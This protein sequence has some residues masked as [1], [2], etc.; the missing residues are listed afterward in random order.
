[1]APS[2][3]SGL[4]GPVTAG[5]HY[6]AIVESSDDA[7]LSKDPDGLITSWN[8]AAERMY[9]Y[10][11]EEAVGSHISILIPKH[12]S[13]EE[14][15]ILDRIL[16][17]E[18]VDH[19][20]TERVRKDGRQINVSLSVSPVRGADGKVE[21][22]SVIARDI[23]RQ[24]R[25]LALAARLQ[26]TTG[27]LAQ[28]TTQDK[29]IEVLLNQMVGALGAQAGAV[30]LVSGD[31][32]LVS[33][34]TGYSREG[35]EGWAR[36]P[37]AADLPMSEAIRDCEALWMTTAEEL[38]TR[39]P[40]LAGAAVRFEA[41]AIL[42]LAVGDAPFGCV[43]LSFVDGRDFDPEER[44]FL[45]AASQQAAYA[46]N[47][48][49]MYESQRIA[50]ER[51]RFLAEAGELLASSLNPETA[52]DQLASLAVRHIADWCGVEMVDERGGLHSVVVAHAD[53]AKVELARQLRERY[54]VDPRSETGAPHVIRTGVAEV[55]PEVTD[56]MLAE[57]ARDEEH[58]RYLRE[59]GLRSAMIVP[60]RARGR[61][62]GA[63]TFV[64]SSPD[65]HYGDDDVELAE[66][67]AR[68]A[69][70]AVDNAML[71]RREHEA[72]VILQRSLLPDSVPTHHEGI[73][74]DVR[75][76]PAGPGI[77]VG[78]DWY[79]IVVLDDGTVGLTIGDVA[80]R[81][82]IAASVMGRI[83]PALRA[84]VLDGHNPA[85]AVE[86]LDRLMKDSP[87]PNMAT[88]FHLHYDPKSGSASY[89]RAGH[90]PALVRGPDGSVQELDGA[91][92]PPLGVLEEVEYREHEV[93]IEPGS[94]LLMYTDGLIERRDISLRRE[95]ERL[96][97]LLAEAPG[98]TTECL[99][100]LEHN[101][102]A[103]AVPDD[104]AMVAM[105]TPRA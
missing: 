23:T 8:P 24:Q 71:F 2:N 95:L 16:R 29:V 26:E 105:T 36:F 51:Q 68:R 7:I 5:E 44:A 38:V 12:R 40:A 73:G 69:A 50:S 87:V 54:P 48:A 99:D 74:F 92:T 22:A 62:F 80:G 11:A 52:L 77:A 83:R 46:M 47:R 3:P 28:E 1:M 85:E 63:I 53:E 45:L 14:G 10:S 55:Y 9:G 104:I 86:R 90:P 25:T 76:R 32:I 57:A 41:L 89:V 101:L 82:L 34:T 70:L 65:R 39:F 30:G 91:G 20:E 19:Y 60:L 98:G 94:L 75:Y 49:R 79:D 67:L 103:D 64:A 59:L 43:S 72:A 78:G 61:V 56:E 88:V 18:H 27:A 102:D 93:E 37:V 13:G 21:A 97:D 4:L 96:K 58:L 35:L 81:G 42:P 100:W 6:A 84:Y 66:D 17:G 15:R 31:D 33:D